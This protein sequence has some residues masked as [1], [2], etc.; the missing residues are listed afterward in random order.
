MPVAAPTPLDPNGLGAAAS[1]LSRG[2]AKN[3]RTALGLASVLLE[4]GE[5]VECVVAGKVNELDGLVCL[6]NRRLFVLNDRQ[7][8]PDQ[9]SLPVDAAMSVRGEVAG[10]AA[11]I[12]IQREAHA[13]VITRIGDLPLAQELAQR[14]RARAVGG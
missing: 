3:A 4:D 5:V 7:W 13:A 6:T 2:S 14:I 8:V 1:R 11:S 10:S 9:L 12:T